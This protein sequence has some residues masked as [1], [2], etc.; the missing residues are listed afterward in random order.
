MN[1]LMLSNLKL[2]VDRIFFC[3]M[4]VFFVIWCV[5]FCEVL[6]GVS[7]FL[8]CVTFCVILCVGFCLNVGL[9]SS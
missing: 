4:Y 8:W 9:M 1:F 3:Y 2:I 7:Y 5:G 6:C